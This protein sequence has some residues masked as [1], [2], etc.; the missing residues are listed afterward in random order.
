M[1]NG[2]PWLLAERL[3]AVSVALVLQQ[4]AFRVLK[5]I[6]KASHEHLA[7]DYSLCSNLG[8]TGA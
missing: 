5:M 2:S 3:K 6:K 7:G 1:W 4:W 8:R